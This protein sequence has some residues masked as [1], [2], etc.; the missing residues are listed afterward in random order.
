M[1]AAMRVTI[2]TA[3]DYCEAVQN[4]A[5]C[6]EQPELR[7]GRAEADALGLP[8]P[9]TGAF[10]TVFRMECPTGD[11][12]VRCFLRRFDDRQ[13]R[14]RLLAGFVSAAR[15]EWLVPAEYLERGIRARGGWYPILKMN[16]VRGEL[17]DRHVQANLGNPVKLRALA[18]G[19][20]RMAAALEAAG[21]AHGDLQH[22]NVLVTGSGLRLVDYD[23]MFV[24]G[25]EGEQAPEKGHENYQP[26][27][28]TGT[29]FGPGLDRFSE[30]VVYLSLLALASD[31]AL[32]A[33]HRGG[34]EALLLRKRDYEAPDSSALL[35][36]LRASADK[37]VRR[38]A[39]RLS[40]LCLLPVAGMPP[41]A[42]ALVKKRGKP[43]PER[44]PAAKPRQ[45]HA[46]GGASWIVDY[47][48]ESSRGGAG[49]PFRSSPA[50]E[51]CLLLAGLA[52]AFATGASPAALALL[53]G[54]LAAFLG[55]SALRYRAEPCI[56]GPLGLPPERV[57]FLTL[58]FIEG[59]RQPGQ[60]SRTG[61][62]KFL[63][64][65]W[66]LGG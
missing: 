31:P 9:R 14:Y 4:A 46:L 13:R 1:P 3:A 51:R 7:Q 38:L 55:I 2:P 18:A 39:L 53:A 10:A 58:L 60:E 66:R 57:T 16:W 45:E 34:D 19:W 36:E 22:G 8:R 63:F 27:S 64:R 26:P 24:P 12:A 52:A 25:L 5:F 28:R 61:F 11:F 40:E 47:L 43:S 50:A 41:L 54:S 21:A 37:E 30:W 49:S 59:V 44:T 23:G 33:R 20:A 56:A 42:D 15:L 35:G 48:P 62:A 32:W 17:L 29:D 6:F 65:P